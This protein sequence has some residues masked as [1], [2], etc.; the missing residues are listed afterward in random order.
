M[1]NLARREEGLSI[2]KAPAA[3]SSSP[4]IDKVEILTK[5]LRV[6]CVVAVSPKIKHSNLINE[7]QKFG[8]T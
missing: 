1:A 2:S 5:D 4:S 3:F 6:V 7:V 8:S